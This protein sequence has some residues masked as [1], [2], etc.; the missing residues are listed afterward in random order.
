MINTD[1]EEYVEKYCRK[2][3]ISKEEAK[4]HY[5]VKEYQKWKEEHDGSETGLQSIE[6]K[7]Q[8]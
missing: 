8:T 1:F 7:S 2:H 6:L 4:T 5:L 3:G